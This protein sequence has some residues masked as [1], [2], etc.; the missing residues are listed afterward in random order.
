MPLATTPLIGFAMEFFARKDVNSDTVFI[1]MMT[2]SWAEILASHS[3]RIKC[4]VVKRNCY[5]G[6]SK[7]CL[8]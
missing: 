3:I 7:I 4:I 5:A 2:W 8:R 1:V 6:K